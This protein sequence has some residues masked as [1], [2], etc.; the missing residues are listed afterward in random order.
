MTV[1]HG[2]VT[3]T[4]DEITLV[5][6][7]IIVDPVGQAAMLVGAT[8]IPAGDILSSVIWTSDPP[9]RLDQALW[10]HIT[11]PGG[12]VVGSSYYTAAVAPEPATLLLL[13][14]GLT[15]LGTLAWR[16]RR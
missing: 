16:R 6:S 10:Q 8:D 12:S 1:S 7:S 11:V 4:E 15:A 9:P 5:T 3:W 13:G 14:S 2:G